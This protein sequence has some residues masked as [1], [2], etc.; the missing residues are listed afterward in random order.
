[1]KIVNGRNCPKNT[2][3]SRHSWNRV[4]LAADKGEFQVVLEPYNPKQLQ[5]PALSTISSLGK[6]DFRTT[7]APSR[8]CNDNSIYFQHPDSF[9]QFNQ[10]KIVPAKNLNTNVFTIQ[11][12][13]GC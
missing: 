10:W 2:L 11:S 7:I 8:H 12:T 4:N 1:M 5:L 3:S 13:R 6:K 9:D